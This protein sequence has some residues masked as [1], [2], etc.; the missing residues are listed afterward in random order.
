MRARLTAIQPPPPRQTGPT[1][2]TFTPSGGG[3]ALTYSGGAH[4]DWT[5]GGFFDC[6]VDPAT[7]NVS[8]ATPAQDVGASQVL[9]RDLRTVYEDLHTAGQPLLEKLAVDD[10]R[11]FNLGCS[12]PILAFLR[13]SAFLDPNVKL[14]GV[15]RSFAVH[16]KDPPPTRFLVQAGMEEA[17]KQGVFADAARHA[18]AMVA[19][20]QSAFK[21]LAR[22]RGHVHRAWRFQV[23]WRLCVGM[24]NPSPWEAGMALHPLFGVPILPANSV[25]S[26]AR[27]G[28]VLA[29]IGED[30]IAAVLGSPPDPRTDSGA[31][32][33]SII[34]PDALPESTPEGKGVHL[35]VDVLTPHTKEV[36]PDHKM[37]PVPSTFLTVAWPTVFVIEAIGVEN[38]LDRQVH[39]WLT[40]QLGEWGIGAKLSAG[41][42]R[43][44]YLPATATSAP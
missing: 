5:R 44:V 35:E 39:P 7:G 1:N 24:G 6:L 11:L 16:V 38:V 2:Y 21:L 26:A 32:P 15:N 20:R 18:A 8:S 10:G 17:W 36:G 23:K 22:Q 13:H 29:G 30:K 31:A 28:A 12:S 9:P 40:Q 27:R 43:M 4:R 34:L 33:R 42:G 41:Y 14:K 3:R 25:A 37:N 19:R